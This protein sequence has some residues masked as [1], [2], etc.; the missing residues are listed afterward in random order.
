[1]CWLWPD[2]GVEYAGRS[3]AAGRVLPLGAAAGRGETV[4]MELRFE[5]GEH[6]GGGGADGA[7]AGECVEVPGVGGLCAR[8]CSPG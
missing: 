4:G 8:R 7:G 2:V 5:I 3:M 6:V 1:M